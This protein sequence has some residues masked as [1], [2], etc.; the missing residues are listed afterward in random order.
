MRRSEEASGVPSWWSPLGASQPWTRA[1]LFWAIIYQIDHF[2]L[3]SIWPGI[4]LAYACV[5]AGREIRRRR[6]AALI[7]VG[8][9]AAR[10]QSSAEPK[11]VLVTKAPTTSALIKKAAGLSSR[12]A[13]A[14]VRQASS[15]SVASPSS[16]WT[17]SPASRSRIPT[18]PELEACKNMIRGTAK[19]MGVD[20]GGPPK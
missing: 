20:I 1:T 14:R 8:W 19:S 13:L 7:D 6:R 5:G 17:R 11:V 2:F 10:Q 9:Q 15:R 3:G 12:R 16:S 18:R 4:A